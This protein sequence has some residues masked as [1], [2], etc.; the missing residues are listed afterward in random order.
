MKGWSIMTNTIELINTLKALNF[1]N[2]QIVAVITSTNSIPQVAKAEVTPEV[3]PIDLASI[4]GATEEV[5]VTP[6]SCRITAED[7]DLLVE[8]TAT[9]TRNAQLG[10]WR[11]ISRAGKPYIWYGW[12][13]EKADGTVKPVFP[14]KQLY[15][16]NDF[17]LQRDYGAYHPGRTTTY[18]FRDNGAKAFITSYQVR[19][20]VESK[21]SK[22]FMEYMKKKEEA[23]A[24]RVH[25]TDEC[26]TNWCKHS[27]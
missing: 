5:A 11:S 20:E 24:E 22:A 15:Y 4:F 2:E 21:D 13:V 12:G 26:Y 18:K 16:V 6:K 3:N 27:K 23:R 7:F 25:D 14:G 10:A 8:E 9:S 1:T 19:R 17:Y